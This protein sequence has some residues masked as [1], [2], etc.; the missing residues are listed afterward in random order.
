MM[1]EQIQIKIGIRS[2]L[3]K[4]AKLDLRRLYDDLIGSD[5]VG[6][7]LLKIGT[8]I[9]Q[10][11]DLPVP[12]TDKEKPRT[13]IATIRKEL[14]SVQAR[15]QMIKHE[16][17]DIEKRLLRDF[18][19][20]VADL[21]K[22]MEDLPRRLFTAPPPSEG[23]VPDD[24]ITIT[25]DDA[26]SSPDGI[27]DEEDDDYEGEDGNGEEDEDQ[28][29]MMRKVTALQRLDETSI[30]ECASFFKT[31]VEV[32][33]RD[34]LT[35]IPIEGI[36]GGL[37]PH[38]MLAVWFMLS[39]EISPRRGGILADE[40]GL[41]KTRTLIAACVMGRWL[42]VMAEGIETSWQHG[43]ADHLSKSDMT[44]SCPSAGKY[45]L[46][47]LCEA[48]NPF[49][50]EKIIRGLNLIMSPPA[51][52]HNWAQEWLKVVDIEHKELKMQL[53]WAYCAAPSIADE[54]L[55]KL[56]PH[57]RSFSAII[58]ESPDDFFPADEETRRDAKLRQKAIAGIA[59]EKKNRYQE[60]DTDWPNPELTE[61][62]QKA[63]ETEASPVF[64]NGMQRYAI[65]TSPGCWENH[66][67]KH[68]AKRVAFSKKVPHKQE[69]YSCSVTFGRLLFGRFIRD[70]CHLEPRI[71]SK[72]LSII[73]RM[74]ARP[75]SW[76]ASGTPFEKD[77]RD[78]IGFISI[79]DSE[80]SKDEALND[81]DHRA[82]EALER[83]FKKATSDEEFKDIGAD[84][85]KK[86]I[87]VGYI[88]RYR[89]SD[90][91]GKRLTN[92]PDLHEREQDCPLEP[93]DRTR[94]QKVRESLELATD[95][96]A[97]GKGEGAQALKQKFYR[98]YQRLI[99]VR[100]FPG[101]LDVAGRPE[102]KT[103]YWTLETLTDLDKLMKSQTRNNTKA[104]QKKD[105]AFA[106]V[107][108]LKEHLKT[109]I[110]RS[111][112]WKALCKEI[113]SQ[114]FERGS[115]EHRKKLLVFSH[116][117]LIA[118]IFFLAL[119]DKYPKLYPRLIV[120]TMKME[121]RLNI[122]NLFN[123]RATGEEHPELGHSPGIIVS[124]MSILGYGFNLERAD[125]V[126]IT[127]RYSNHSK[128]RQ[129]YGRIAR[130]GQEN[131]EIHGV[132][133]TD[134]KMSNEIK[135]QDEIKRRALVWAQ[136]HNV[137]V[138]EEGEVELGE[139]DENETA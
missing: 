94:I 85:A 102:L 104:G 43:K 127:E 96:L 90:W 118:I 122:A 99:V 101:V 79:L 8:F 98:P 87:K 14:Q 29:Q 2:E 34:P 49:K 11:L 107:Y 135:K 25:S 112:R 91:F 19:N 89:D 44:G 128:S 35:S 37:F 47:C 1:L 131:S 15:L 105:E 125:K 6:G 92:I 16:F 121:D 97:G 33:K 111:A 62:H 31:P 95:Q 76:F 27:I 109:I 63:L 50:P 108:T 61:A 23:D 136:L 133:L 51:L 68:Y 106:S 130:L 78:L 28:E 110:R 7:D 39:A 55:L 139:Q 13:L 59:F 119:Q 46:R 53:C 17:H 70:E 48:E 81:C 117:P 86:L 57:I 45:P 67:S 41:G 73:A 38:Q 66:V 24:V 83:R 123:D 9:K 22:K 88:Q 64:P 93:E 30:E 116:H 69:P 77:P 12:D 138:N 20:E 3:V 36:K 26:E 60:G 40:M 82:F 74:K 71:T 114:R 72:A 42:E 103:F 52:T 126:I 54:N 129:A 134:R 56:R 75:V 100:T 32:L 18:M 4:N 58:E 84:L 65:L 113:E 115:T 80:F 21:A 120:S 124:T 5:R 137:K 132:V 10:L